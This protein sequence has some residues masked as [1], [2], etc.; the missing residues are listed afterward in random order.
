MPAH[1]PGTYSNTNPVPKQPQPAANARALTTE[2]KAAL[3]DQA[4]A[5]YKEARQAQA[6]ID[7]LRYR[8]IN[9][10]IQSDTLFSQG[11]PDSSSTID[12]GP[13]SQ[14]G[15]SSCICERIG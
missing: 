2:E 10:Q 9:L 1:A 12:L 8:L 6:E 5:L 14:C 13:C 7:R 15:F 4:Q 3:W 11:R